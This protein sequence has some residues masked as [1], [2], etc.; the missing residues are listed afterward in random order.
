MSHGFNPGFSEFR[1]SHHCVIV[2]IVGSAKP[3]L[4]GSPAT[5]LKAPEHQVAGHQ[6]RD[7]QLGP[8]VD[9][10]GMFYKPL[11]SD[12]RGATELAFYTSFSSDPQ[13]PAQIR[14][15]FPGF[16]GT[17]LLHASDGSGLHPHLVLDDLLAGFRLPSVI[18]VKIGSRTWLPSSSDDYFRKCVAKDIETTSALLGFRISGLQINDDR[19]FWRPG[20]DAVRRFNSNDVRRALRRFV[21]SDP[22]ASDDCEPDCAFAPAVYGGSS[23]VLS[24]L[25]EL[26]SWFEVQTLFHFCSASVLVAYEKDGS[27]NG[28][29]DGGSGGA[30]V[31]LV[32]FAH[33]AE[34]D[35]VID[36]N[37]LGGLC[38]LIKFISDILQG[39]CGESSDAKCYLNGDG[40]IY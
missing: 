36:H 38:S 1:R 28:D 2:S 9:G 15:F 10:S 16:H 19:G 11:Q 17:Q 7:G 13:I 26:K 14:S 39:F 32:D 31:R 23:G 34:G 35:G 25:L 30:R 5:M 18:D 37:F 6:A 12:D 33:V 3:N 21:S 8:L 24:Q 27:K 4:A 29:G 40:K 22:A 20:R